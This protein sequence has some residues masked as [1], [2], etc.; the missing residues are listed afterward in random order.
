MR[1]KRADRR[2][3]GLLGILGA[4]LALPVTA[5]A[6]RSVRYVFRRASGRDH[7]DALNWSGDP[8]KAAALDAP[9]PPRR[10]SA[11]A[12]HAD[13]GRSDSTDAR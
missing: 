2:W 9:V 3:R 12:A 1:R 11:E 5:A 6:W 8:A 4:V 7:D 13:A 10:G